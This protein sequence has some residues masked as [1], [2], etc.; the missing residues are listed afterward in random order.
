MAK[1][2]D[3]HQFAPRHG[4][5]NKEL[6]LKRIGWLY[7]IFRDVFF[8]HGLLARF[9]HHVAVV[10]EVNARSQGCRGAIHRARLPTHCTL[11][12]VEKLPP[13]AV[14]TGPFTESAAAVVRSPG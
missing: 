8:Y 4:P 2:G 9:F 7:P 11:G 14:A 12:D 10:T 1:N 6:R 5:R 13:R 3:C